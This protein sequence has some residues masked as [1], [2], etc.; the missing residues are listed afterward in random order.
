MKEYIK[1]NR[2]FCKERSIRFRWINWSLQR[3]RRKQSSNSIK[4]R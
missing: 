2:W 1:M 3:T 4:S